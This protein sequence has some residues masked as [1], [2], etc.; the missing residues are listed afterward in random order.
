LTF[1]ARSKETHIDKLEPA[2]I[3][4]SVIRGFLADL[5]R[6]RI[7]AS[8]SGR[9]LSALRT[10]I[11]YLRREELVDNNPSALVSAPKQGV[12]IP[13]HLTVDEM[14]R[15]LEM[16]GPSMLLGLLDRAIPE[17]FNASGL[18]LREPVALDV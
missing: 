16:P 6:R 15:L 4:V 17:L 1:V 14:N 18:R 13:S 9:K 8:S 5:H 12:T 2:D 7:S 11:R 3:E 10:F